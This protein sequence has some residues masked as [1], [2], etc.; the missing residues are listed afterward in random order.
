MVDQSKHGLRYEPWSLT[1][2][3][4][5]GNDALKE[6]RHRAYFEWQ[7]AESVPD[8]WERF[9]VAIPDFSGARILDLGCGHGSL[10]VDVAR[11]G[12]ARAVGV[13]IDRDR[14]EF[15]RRHVD[16][17]LPD[18]APKIEFLARD[19]AEVEGAFD[20]VVSK[21]T[22]EHI[23]DLEAVMRHVHRLLKPGGRLLVGSS[24]LFYSPFGDHE[25]YWGSRFLPWLPVYVPES[26]LLKV[27]KW[28]RASERRGVMFGDGEIGLNKLTPA[29]FRALLKPENWRAESI[30]YNSGEKALLKPM[31]VLRKIPTLERFFTTGVYAVVVRT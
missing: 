15:A 11:R 23:D 28:R 2:L 18:L 22:F 25:M 30:K 21:D 10:T 3:P 13:D 1:R 7:L 5:E 17:A 4:G 12:A 16:S 9:Q 24:P 31:R 26:V 8:W 20:F 19:I 6:R 14:I 29:Q 27:A